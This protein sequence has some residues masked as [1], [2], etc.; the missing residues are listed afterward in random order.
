[1][2]KE[3]WMKRWQA[4]QIGFHEDQ[5]NLSLQE[6]WET[7]GAKEG[8]TVFVPLCGKSRD[9]L[10]LVEQG[11]QVVAVELSP[12]AV[13]DFF[14]EHNL[15]PSTSQCGELTCYKAGPFTLYCGDLFKLKPTHLNNCQWVYDRAA[16]I[17]LPD[18]MRRDYC[19]Y[20][21]SILPRPCQSLLL[22]V[23][24]NTDKISGPPFSITADMLNSLVGDYADITRLG[25]R[26]EDIKG[27][28]GWEH[29]FILRYR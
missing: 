27:H 13:E 14:Q 9:M 12:I 2:E 10:Y 22:T 8:E 17:A 4:Q 19:H 20:L 23:E 25:A 28:P 29:S 5:F 6:H 11:L 21:A 16:L 24:Y 18:A 1:M 26:K 3:F 7:L 15:T